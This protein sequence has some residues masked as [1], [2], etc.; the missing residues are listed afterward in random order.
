MSLILLF[1]KRIADAVRRLSDI[2]YRD[3][4]SLYGAQA[5]FFIL[6]SVIP[7]GV[8]VV[9]LIRHFSPARFESVCAIFARYIPDIVESALEAVAGGGS[10]SSV[11]LVPVTLITALWSASRGTFALGTG[12]AYVYGKERRRSYL[13]LRLLFLVYTFLIIAVIFLAATLLSFGEIIWAAADAS[14]FRLPIGG[15]YIIA[16]GVLTLFFAMMY[17][18]FTRTRNGR[19]DYP[20][21]SH[22]PGA[23]FSAVGWVLFSYF[24]SLYIE[25]FPRN[26][27][28]Y[29]SLAAI[30]FFL[31]WLYFC[32]LIL[33]WGAEIN[34]LAYTK[35]RVAH[36]KFTKN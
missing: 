23:A 32:M 28:I 36:Q 18:L 35:V 7:F 26:S 29:G 10:V 14:G 20:F 34:K 17:Y 16:L 24:Y 22:L 3:R 12:I 11:R 8:T 1:V 33:L 27:Y 6:L 25:Y 21:A 30:V 9:A 15:R 31:L 4:I 13:T 19:T 5:S 2:A